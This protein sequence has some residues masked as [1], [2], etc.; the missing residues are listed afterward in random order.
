M[1]S[2]GHPTRDPQVL[3]PTGGIQTCLPVAHHVAPSMSW[4][5][6]TSTSTTQDPREGPSLARSTT[7]RPPRGSASSGWLPR[8]GE[9]YARCTSRGSADV[10]HDD[11]GHA[12]TSRRRAPV[13]SLVQ[14]RQAAGAESRGI[15]QRF[16]FW[17]NETKTSRTAGWRTSPS[18]LMRIQT[19][20]RVIVLTYTSY[21]R[22]LP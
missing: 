12:G 13:S 19:W 8:G 2:L 7:P 17:C 20:G 5:D 21:P 16:P 14:R 4:Y 11:Q 10:S 15:S 3:T 22:S 6:P 18:P 1:H 9:F